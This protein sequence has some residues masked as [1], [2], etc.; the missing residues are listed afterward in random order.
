[1]AKVDGAKRRLLAHFLANIGRVMD[2]DE[3]RPI[4]NNRSEWARRVRELRDEQ[5]Y[6]ILSHSDRADLKPGQYLMISAERKEAAERAISKETRARVLELYGSVCYSCGAIA[7]E[8]NPANGKVTVLHMGH[9]K[10]KSHG[11]DD[12]ISNL[13]PVCMVCNTGASNTTPELPSAKRIISELR[14]APRSDQFD[15]YTWLKGKF[16][17]E[18]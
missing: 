18:I 3:L 12:T 11:G 14:K 17:P 8:P 7:G 1:M 9:I 10:A 16:E 2:R 4:A 13:R 6:Q 5:G 15:V